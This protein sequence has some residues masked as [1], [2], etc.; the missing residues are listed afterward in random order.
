MPRNIPGCGSGFTMGGG[1]EG[2]VGVTGRG[3]GGAAA[4]TT[5]MGEGVA[6]AA[7]RWLRGRAVSKR[8][9][10]VGLLTL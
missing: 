10:M 9:R 5:I 4:A 2:T 1:M 7:A 3:S 6:A 8:C